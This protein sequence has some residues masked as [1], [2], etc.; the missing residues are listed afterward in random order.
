M[1]SV[2]WGTR[3]LHALR[4]AHS[5]DDDNRLSRRLGGRSV[6]SHPPVVRVGSNRLL[7]R[8]AVRLPVPRANRNFIPGLVWHITHRCHDRKFLLRASA[9]RDGWRRWLFEARVRYGLCVLNYVVTSN[10]IHLLVYDQGVPEQLARSMQLVQGRVAQAYNRRRG[11]RGAFWQDRYHGVA[12]DSGEYLRRCLV[13]IDL[14]MVRAAVVAHPGEWRHGGFNEIQSPRS[15][16][17]VLDLDCL[18]KLTECGDVPTLQAAHREWVDCALGAGASARQPE[19]TEGIAIGRRSFTE[20]VRTQLGLGRR[21]SPGTSHADAH[22]LGNFAN[23]YP[24]K[25]SC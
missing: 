11:R 21:S 24:Q 20:D 6:D 4:H 19:W 22:V 12:V 15:R 10:H 25:P 16:Y 1:K 9:E 14:N 5:A 13:Y 17:R 8:F 3:L 2:S 23:A 18:A 7:V